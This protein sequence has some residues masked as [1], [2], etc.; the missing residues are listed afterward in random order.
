VSAF[1]VAHGE[2]VKKLDKAQRDHAFPLTV[3]RDDASTEFV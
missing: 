1:G 3:T 2:W